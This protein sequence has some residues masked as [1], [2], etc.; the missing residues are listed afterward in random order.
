MGFSGKQREAR[1]RRDYAACIICPPQSDSHRA[2]PRSP[3]TWLAGLRQVIETVNDRLRETF[4]LDH[5]RPHDVSGLL[6]RLAAKV[7]LHNVCLWLNRRLGR[8]DLAFADLIDW[9]QVHPS[10]TKR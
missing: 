5:E 9:Q 10:P 3:R 6:A 7:G 8:P 2:W 4:R 1:W